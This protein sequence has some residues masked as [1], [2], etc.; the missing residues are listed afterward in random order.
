MT[1]RLDGQKPRTRI[2]ALATAMLASCAHDRPDVATAHTNGPRSLTTEELVRLRC[3]LDGREVLTGWSGEVFG[4][5]PNERPR[6][7]FTVVGMNVAR[8]I[9]SEGRWHLTSRELMLYLDPTTGARLDRW[10]NPW[11]GATVPV[12]HVANRLVQNE[13]AGPVPASVTDGTVTV[14]FDIPL[15]YPDPVAGDPRTASYSAGPNYVA[16]ELFAFE[17]TAASGLDPGVVSVH[18]L[19]FS[20]HR[21]GPWLPWMAMR[22]RPGMLVYRAHGRKLGG[23]ADLA[24]ELQQEIATNTPLYRHA[25]RCAV[26]ARNETSWTYFVRHVAAYEVG[27]RFPR[28]APEDATECRPR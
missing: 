26:N 4:F 17:T 23:F 20:W 28:P 7:L 6:H 8:C 11:T 12:V 3:A 9:Q 1:K 14:T 18:A 21:V 15:F 16:G 25:P 22:D 13:L 5:A 19:R 2:L 10:T 24:A 27:A